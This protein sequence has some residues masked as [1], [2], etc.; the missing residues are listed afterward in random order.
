[1]CTNWDDDRPNCF[2][3]IRFTR[4][5]TD[6]HTQTDHSTS[7]TDCEGIISLRFKDQDFLITNIL[8]KSAKDLMKKYVLKEFQVNVYNL[9][10]LSCETIE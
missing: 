10:N 9:F 8:Q 4:C 5:V 7:A 3:S 2:V 1:M 6:V